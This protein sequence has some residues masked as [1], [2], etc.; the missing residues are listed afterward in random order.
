MV[1]LS[2]LRYERWQRSF[3][4]SVVDIVKMG[5]LNDIQIGVNMRNPHTQT[6]THTQTYTTRQLGAIIDKSNFMWEHTL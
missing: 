5:C 4:F 3:Q 6:C 2:Q 1:A